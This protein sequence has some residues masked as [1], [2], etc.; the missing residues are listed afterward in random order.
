MQNTLS[1]RLTRLRAGFFVGRKNQ[2]ERF[3]AFLDDPT[4]RILHIIG[5][6]GIGK[7]SLIRNFVRHCSEQEI[8]FAHLDARQVPSDPQKFI[9]KLRAACGLP[10]DAEVR[11]H[12]QKPGKFVLFIDTYEELAELE[13]W[14]VDHFF[15]HLG[16]ECR[17]VLASR[18]P[19]SSVWRDDPAWRALSDELSLRHLT[20]EDSRELL[21]LHGV[22]KEQQE[23][24]ARLSHGNPLVLSLIA[25]V[26]TDDPSADI[27]GG[28][29][30]DRVY[31]LMERMLD[32][33]PSDSHL[34]ALQ[35]SSM[36]RAVTEDSLSGILG[37]PN[38][39]EVFRWLANLSFMR[40]TEL[41]LTP[42]DLIR[43]IVERDLKLRLPTRHE[44]LFFRCRR[45]LVDGL[46]NSKSSNRQR[47]MED[48]FYLFRDAPAFRAIFGGHLGDG[49]YVD[50]GRPEEY[51]DVVAT[52]ETFEGQMAA[53]SARYWLARPESSLQMIRDATTAEWVGFLLML[54]FTKGAEPDSNWDPVLRAMWSYVEDCE[55][56][57]DG[58]VAL[59]GRFWM[60]RDEYQAIGPV[61]TRIFQQVSELQIL[62]P[63]L[64]FLACTIAHPE[65]WP[66]VLEIQNLAQEDLHGVPYGWFGYNRRERPVMEWIENYTG[67]FDQLAPKPTPPP[68]GEQVYAL[69]R[70][71]F[72]AAVKDALRKWRKPDRLE[73]S[74]LLQSRLVL[75]RC[76]AGCGLDEKI[77]VL[78]DTLASSVN[79]F[80]GA[81]FDDRPRA[82]LRTT[83]FEENLKQL[84]IAQRLNLPFSTYRY[85]LAQALERL[86]DVLWRMEAGDSPTNIDYSG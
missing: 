30:V 10:A 31:H 1:E 20:H 67:Q 44:D 74:P 56:L 78:R 16:S 24:A 25:Q 63:G 46:L 66:M 40:W 14:L 38:A 22:K 73:Q 18:Q 17:V 4:V 47:F 53:E 37:I 69:E 68:I 21:N 57:R 84:A 60:S 42:H 49:F 23:Q 27:S 62:T 76:T 7:T 83:Y 48:F 2:R 13:G 55:G 81:D 33:P 86:C 6:G 26:L 80:P 70:S 50:P 71:A 82:V 5:P 77:K 9:E 51:A 79:D 54:R 29:P 85:H 19:P 58:E 15:P 52:I 65:T 45:Y 11:R 32:R 64:A 36:M 75:D 39:S 72:D 61:Q 8:A 3:A 41:G 12:L 34:C 28:L 59:F 43:E 35:V